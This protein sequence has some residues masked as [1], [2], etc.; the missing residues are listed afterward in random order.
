MWCTSF[1]RLYVQWNH[2]A[3]CVFCSTD[4]CKMWLSTNK[5]FMMVS[6]S[7]CR[8]GSSSM[9]VS[10]QEF[11][12]SRWTQRHVGLSRNVSICMKHWLW[13]SLVNC[14]DCTPERCDLQ[15]YSWQRMTSFFHWSDFIYYLNIITVIIINYTS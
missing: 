15:T 10:Y 1:W 6:I 11:H 7:N 2:M 4:N 12:R 8:F 9:S 3:D 5:Q 14:K 13:Q